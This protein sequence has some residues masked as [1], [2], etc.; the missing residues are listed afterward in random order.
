MDRGIG[1][2]G[3]CAILLNMDENPIIRPKIPRE[4]MESLVS[5][6]DYILTIPN[7][8]QPFTQVE[9]LAILDT[10]EQFFAAIEMSKAREI[11]RFKLE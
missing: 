9:R 8:N 3:T 6:F 11:I 10:Y 2:P 5:V 7:A 1:E 4:R